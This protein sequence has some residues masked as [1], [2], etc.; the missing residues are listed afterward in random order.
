M[1]IFALT[2]I[3][4]L[5]AVPALA[6]EGNGGKPD[7]AAAAAN[8]AALG[9]ISA[10]TACHWGPNPEDFGSCVLHVERLSLAD[11]DGGRTLAFQCD[12]RF[13]NPKNRDGTR[14]FGDCPQ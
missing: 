6:S 13:L 3:L 9:A 2:A 12:P 7:P 11:L 4:A 10:N 5:A 1:K 8:A 14:L